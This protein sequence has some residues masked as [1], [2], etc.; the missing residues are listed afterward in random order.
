MGCQARIEADLVIDVPPESQIHKQV[1][2]KRAEVRDIQMDPATR[3]YYVTVAEPD[4]HDPSGDWER[5]AT[6]LA[7]QWEIAGVAADPGILAGL[8]KA[9]RKGDWAV[10][11]AVHQDRETN[12]PK[13]VQV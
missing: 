1:V 7:D 11:C 9:L 13:V 3:L 4:M 5:L 8:Q 10:T 2:R 12:I 6:A